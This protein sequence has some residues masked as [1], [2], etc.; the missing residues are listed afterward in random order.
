MKT[1]AKE[2]LTYA[3]LKE[4]WTLEQVPG[5][6]NYF[7]AEEDQAMDHFKDTIQRE[8]DGRYQVKLPRKTPTPELGQSGGAA[9][10]RFLQNERSLTKKEERPTTCIPSS[11]PRI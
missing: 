9:Q 7:T 10:R 5:C 8:P 11:C 4:F 3:L 1:T 6:S 2:D